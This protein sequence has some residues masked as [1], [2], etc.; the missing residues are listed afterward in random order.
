MRKNATFIVSLV[1]SVAVVVVV[2]VIWHGSRAAWAV[3]AGLILALIIALA[4]YLTK[5]PKPPTGGST[6][7]SSPT[8]AM[9][10][11]IGAHDQST[12]TGNKVNSTINIFGTPSTQSGLPEDATDTDD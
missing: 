4:M 8:F 6:A 9:G 10:D 12:V 11:V 1:A 3:S 5:Q 2:P 7:S